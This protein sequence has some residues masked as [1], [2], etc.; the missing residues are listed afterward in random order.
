MIEYQNRLRILM[1]ERYISITE[2][3][4]QTGLSRNAVSALKNNK[5]TMIKYQTINVLCEYF[6]I[7][8]GELFEVKKVND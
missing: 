5:S 8:P 1:A 4:K 3:A 6:K 2:L 7:T